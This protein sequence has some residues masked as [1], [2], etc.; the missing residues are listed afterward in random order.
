MASCHNLA[1]VI[2]TSLIFNKKKRIGAVAYLCYCLS[3]DIKL[4]L[5]YS[6][7]GKFLFW[8]FSKIKQINKIELVNVLSDLGFP[9]LTIILNLLKP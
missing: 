3:E 9:K 8:V 4:A 5:I 1:T 7:N 2:L 6:E